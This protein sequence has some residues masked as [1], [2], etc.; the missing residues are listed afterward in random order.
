MDDS[1]TDSNELAFVHLNEDVI[2]PA[3]MLK[4]DNAQRGIPKL[5]FGGCGLLWL[6]FLWKAGSEVSVTFHLIVLLMLIA[7]ALFFSWKPA[8]NWYEIDRKAGAINRWTGKNK[9]RK[10]DALTKDDLHVSAPKLCI[11]PKFSRERYVIVVFGK[12][13]KGKDITIELYTFPKET[14]KEEA[15]AWAKVI[16]KFL[17]DF[18][19]GKTKDRPKE[20]TYTFTIKK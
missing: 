20:K 2:V 17:V 3:G 8:G 1:D 6:F 4:Y 15:E 12:D 5:A 9:K 11:N 14:G 7:V 10:L 16:E 19:D 18:L 13:R